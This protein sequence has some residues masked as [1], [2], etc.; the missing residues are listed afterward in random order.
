M[1]KIEIKSTFGTLLFTHECDE[2]TIRKTVEKAIAEDANLIGAN[3]IGANLRDA[4]LIGAN[5]RDANLRDANLRGANLEGANLIGANL[6]DA[7]LR[8]ANLEG[9]NLIGA[10]LIDANKI[11]MYCKWPIGITDG[12]IHIGCKKQTIEQWDV[13]FAS[14]EV[15]ETPRDT[16]DFKHI[17]ASYLAYKA[18]LTHISK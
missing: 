1:I 18:Y 14:N 6:R 13:F 17:E 9:A 12:L 11:P 4:N 15:Y 16:D 5:L 7:N 3:L 2:N 10:N 8:G